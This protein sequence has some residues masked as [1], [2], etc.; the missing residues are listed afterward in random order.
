MT[1]FDYL[2]RRVAEVARKRRRKPYRMSPRESHRRRR[3]KPRR[4]RDDAY[5]SVPMPERRRKSRRHDG[6][7]WVPRDTRRA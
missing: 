2:E 6:A 1:S 4:Y 5:G 7:L 3:K